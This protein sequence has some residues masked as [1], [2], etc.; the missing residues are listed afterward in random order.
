MRKRLDLELTA[1]LVVAGAAFGIGAE[2][3]AGA[4]QGRALAFLD[5][6]VGLLLPIERWL[7]GRRGEVAVGLLALG[8]VAI[9]LG[10]LI[11]LYIAETSTL[12]G[13]SEGTLVTVCG[14]RSPRRPSR[15]RCSRRW[16]WRAW[17]GRPLR[18]RQQVPELCGRH[19]EVHRVATALS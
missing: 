14:S 4:P 7:G 10:S 13:F 12:F 19:P 2:L 8:G 9:A 15:S 18:G 1:A 5:V 3:S 16:V 17:S 11:S 6:A